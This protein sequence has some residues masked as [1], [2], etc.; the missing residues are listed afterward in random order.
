M[1]LGCLLEF[2]MQNIFLEKSYTKCGGE[3]SPKPFS[4]KSK[5]S[6]SRNQQSKA[7]HSLFL[8]YV[9]VEGYRNIFKSRCR[10]L[11]F[12]SHKAFFKK[13]TLRG[14]EPVYLPHFLQYISIKILLMYILL[15][16]QISLSD[17]L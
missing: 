15:T 12:T 4:K 2:R 8:F 5:L 14:P 13:K 7:L 16:D 9:Q 17:Y 1:K 3:T 6:L 11:A 10:P